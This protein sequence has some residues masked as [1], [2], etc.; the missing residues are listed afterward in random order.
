MTSLL[1]EYQKLLAEYDRVIHAPGWHLGEQKRLGDIL[2]GLV[3]RMTAGERTEALMMQ[4]RL[5]LSHQG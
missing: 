3:D 4:E 2:A 1:T 5:W